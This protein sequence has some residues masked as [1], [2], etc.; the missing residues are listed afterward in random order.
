MPLIRSIV[1]SSPRTTHSE[2]VGYE[3]IVCEDG[4]I[5]QEANCTRDFAAFAERKDADAN[6]NGPDS[7]QQP[8]DCERRTRKDRGIVRIRKDSASGANERSDSG[9]QR[10]AGCWRLY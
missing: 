9:C 4:D 1:S 3:S 10:D 7:S 8:H 6:A 2:E 5:G